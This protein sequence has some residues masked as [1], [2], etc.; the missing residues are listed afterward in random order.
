MNE[1]N[2]SIYSLVL[3]FNFRV[4]SILAQKHIVT[5]TTFMQENKVVKRFG[6]A[7]EF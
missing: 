5:K 6:V 2:K 1:K 7:F 3:P 4:K